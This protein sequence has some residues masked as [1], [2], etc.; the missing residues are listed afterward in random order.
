MAL[1]R[2]ARLGMQ[3]MFQVHVV[4]ILGCVAGEWCGVCG[5]GVV[6]GVW[7]GSGG[8]IRGQ[9]CV[10][11][12]VGMLF[13]LCVGLLMMVVIG[14]LIVCL[15]VSISGWRDPGVLCKAKR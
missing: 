12:H 13:F 14:V 3:T 4:A 9:M 15:C 8:N 2:T 6:W 7:L 5:W 1:G 11:I 10:C